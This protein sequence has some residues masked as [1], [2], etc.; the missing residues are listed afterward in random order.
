MISFIWFDIGYTLLYMDRESRY[1]T[2]LRSFGS[3][4]ALERIEEA[5]HLTDKQFM[6]EYP[7]VFTKGKKAVVPWFLGV[8][9]YR[10]GIK[11]DLCPLAARWLEIQ[12]NS[13][14][15]WRPFENTHQVLAQLKQRGL[16]LGVISNWDPSARN[17]LSNYGL[18]ESFTYVVISSDPDVCW[19]KP[20]SEIFHHALRKAG[21]KGQDWLYLGDNF[22]DDARGSRAVG[23]EA[24]IIN[25][26]ERLGIEEIDD[27]VFIRD[28]S[29][30][31]EY[32]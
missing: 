31:S 4:V 8:L 2:L 17:L 25:R 9:N 13:S 10:L 5:F 12:Q 23:M 6:R 21:L 20:K 22:Y 3:E 1:Q 28:I 32:L 24:L 26:F 29:Q 11:P 19:E 14:D 30:I 16:G 7:G 27:Q 18:L 15:F